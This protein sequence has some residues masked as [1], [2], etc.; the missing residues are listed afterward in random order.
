LYIIEHK[1]GK[2]NVIT[3]ALSRRYI[4]LSQ[5]DHKF[6]G[7][8]SL[9]ELYDTDFDFKDVYENCRKGRTWNKYVMYDSL[10]YHANK[11]C[12]S[13]SSVYLLFLQEAHGG[14]LMEHFR[15]KKTEDLLAPHF[16]WPKMRCDMERY[17]SWCTTCNKAKSRLNPHDLYIPLP[18]PS[19]P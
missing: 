11:L 5:L 9:N 13:A 2:D 14:G 8:E 1:K 3:D 6:F 4:M 19:V 10:L 16:F 12:V 17:V 15:V 7:L 18:V